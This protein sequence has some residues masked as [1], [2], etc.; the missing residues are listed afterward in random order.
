MKRCFKKL[1]KDLKV[2]SKCN[3]CGKKLSK[4]SKHHN[5]CHSCWIKTGK[6]FGIKYN[7]L[8]KGIKEIDK[9]ENEKIDTE[10]F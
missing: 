5:K 9:K 3:I 2:V 7:T 6:K 1:N 10:D 8:K 4:N